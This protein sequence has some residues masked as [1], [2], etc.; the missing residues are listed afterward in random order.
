LQWRLPSKKEWEYAAQGRLSYRYVASNYSNSVLYNTAISIK[1]IQ[2]IQ[3]SSMYKSDTSPFLI[4]D[5]GGN[6]SEFV[7]DYKYNQ[8]VL[9]GNS[10]QDDLVYPINFT[11]YSLAKA[12]PETCGFRLCAGLDSFLE[13]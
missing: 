1:N 11:T 9:K 4:N 10:W 6:L 7:F 5:L 2:Q 3:P 12:P 8:H 13:K